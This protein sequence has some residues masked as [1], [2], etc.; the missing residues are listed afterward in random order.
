MRKLFSATP[1]RIGRCEGLPK[2]DAVPASLVEGTPA[3]LKADLIALLLI[4]ADYRPPASHAAARA[5]AHPA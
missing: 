3:D 1:A 2:S 5:L 4:S